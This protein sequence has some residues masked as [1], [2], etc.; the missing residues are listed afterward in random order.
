MTSKPVPINEEIC[1]HLINAFTEIQEAYRIALTEF[2]LYEIKDSLDV[3]MIERLAADAE[4]F[5]KGYLQ[6]HIDAKVYMNG[7]VV[8]D[9]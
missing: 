6:L 3:T 5:F 1:Q 7:R 9:D 2:A 4:I 8:T